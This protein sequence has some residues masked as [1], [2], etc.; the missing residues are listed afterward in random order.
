MSRYNQASHVFWRCQYHIVWTPKY[1]FRILKNNVGKEVY[2]CIN[3]YCNQL[4]CEVVELNVQIDHV[5]LVV[6]VPP[7]LSI[8][9]LMGVLKGKI[10]LKL[11]SKFPYLR[12]NKLWGNHFWQ[13][14]YFVDSV[15]INEEIIRRY[16]RHQEKKER[17]EQQQLALD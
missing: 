16:V 12:K 4:G 11:F 17:V 3:V 15:G 1:R 10:A 6:K 9:K 14:G 5:H 13:R 2:Q 7:K 8:S